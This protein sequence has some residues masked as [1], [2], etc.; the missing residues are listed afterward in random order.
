MSDD[1]RHKLFQAASMTQDQ[2]LIQ[3]VAKKIGLVKADGTSS[4]ES[5]QFAK[6]HIAWAISNVEFIRSV[7][8]PESARAYVDAHLKD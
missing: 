1:D 6:D 2:D 7:S 8:T 3:R 4:D 5:A